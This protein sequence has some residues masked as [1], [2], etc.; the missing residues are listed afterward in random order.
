M[1]LLSLLFEDKSLKICAAHFN[2]KMRGTESDRDAAFVK[3][4]C[5]KQ[6]ID[7][8]I[9][10]AETQ[11]KNELEARE[12]RYSF[13]ENARA[14]LGFNVIATAHTADDNA[15]TMIFN[16]ARG[17]GLK[18]LCGIPER[19]GN[20][21]RPILNVSRCEIEKY[22]E[23]H[24]IPHVEDSSNETDDYSRNLIR[25]K[26]I[27]VLKEINPKLT[28][29]LSRTAEILK[30]DEEFI[31]SAAEKHGID[32]LPA[33]PEA[34]ASRVAM[35]FCPRQLTAQNVRQ[36][37]EFSKGTEYGELDLPG[38]KLV[39]DHGK[40]STEQQVPEFRIE[41]EDCIAGQVNK[42]LNIC[43]IKSDS[44]AGELKC[45]T[46][47]SGDS[48]RPLGRKCTKSLKKLFSEAGLSKAEKENWPVIRDDEG[49]L[50]VYKLAL[51]ERAMARPGE[52]AVKVSVT[53]ISNGK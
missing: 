40:I 52:K 5:E 39:R 3:D 41:L 49:V 32:E 51:A 10:E 33:L 50:Y 11:L 6:G 44:I 7:C 47:Q 53:E 38:V 19:R 43:H 27:P 23:E 35:N 37:I 42:S 20:I 48:I 12:A 22:L 29:T 16:L 1:Y 13:L 25:H 34:L 36:V 24:N 17:T 30:A 18:G 26:I 14:K 8:I 2:H 4:W 21:I 9:G 45:G 28:E 31:S 46:W 15:E